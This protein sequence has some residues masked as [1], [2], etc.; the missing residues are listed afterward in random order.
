M[1]GNSNV[2]EAER[3][4][5]IDLQSLMQPAKVEQGTY[6]S[7]LEKAIAHPQ[8]SGLIAK[9]E[10]IKMG[11][12]PLRN[13]FDS[14][15]RREE[16]DDALHDMN[17]STRKA[18][19]VQVIK[20]PEN[21]LQM[22]QMMGEIEAV[23]FTEE[24]KAIIPEGAIYIAKREE[25]GD[26]ETTAKLTYKTDNI[27]SIPNPAP[28]EQSIPKTGD[29]VPPKKSA[30]D[31]VSEEETKMQAMQIITDDEKSKIVQVL[32][33]KTGLGR[34]FEFTEEQNAAIEH[35][36][37]IQI[38]E[39]ENK[40]LQSVR[41]ERD[42]TGDL[43]FMETASKY[44][45]SL[46][47]TH[48]YFPISGFHADMTGLNYAELSD[49]AL[50]TSG[51]SDD[52]INFNRNWRMLT[53]VY[54]HM[55][56]PSC[57]KFKNFDDFLRKFSHFDLP[58]ALYGLL[59]STQP[60]EDSIGLNCPTENCKK[61]IDVKYSPRSLID[62][63][64]ASPDYLA[65][66]DKLNDARGDALYELAANSPVRT[67]KN[68]KLPSGAIASIGPLNCYDYLYTIMSIMADIK[69]IAVEID[70]NNGEPVNGI[71][72]DDISVKLDMMLLL[73]IVRGFRVPK[74]N[75]S[76]VEILSPEKIL[77]YME[78]YMPIEDY[79][80]LMAIYY[81]AASDYSIGFSFRNVKCPH[82]GTVHKSLSVNIPD[83]V[84]RIHQL[85]V[86]TSVT[87]ET[88]RLF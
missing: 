42:L 12:E 9:S 83:L 74:V 60:E 50:D 19:A 20:R 69:K 6:D 77:E 18:N 79:R 16:F 2:N 28:I 63:T 17:V 71:S 27:T 84:F 45:M 1:N 54:N 41:V 29:Y 36:S 87:A 13:S 30:M 14:D 22:V 73:Y 88:F 7:P 40:E 32:I 65:T 75:D 78:K 86:N 25:S 80:V 26:V 82:C 62:F 15:E 66:M 11:N 67:T 46:A 35:A 23:S 38:V 76:Y 49:I 70:E 8:E 55:V 52:S 24:G 85:L 10:D 53:V 43:S 5:S 61:L 39:V 59:V 31:R 21:Q 3:D 58:L 51:E 37:K 4:L 34:D 47:K 44:Q 64:T 72:V 68:I 33:D 57:G 81:K 56:N 48:I